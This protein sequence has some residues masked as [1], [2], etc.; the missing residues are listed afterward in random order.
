MTVAFQGFPGAYSDLASRTVFPTGKTIPCFSFEE[1]FEKVRKGIVDVG[2]IPIDNSIAGREADIHHLLPES[3][4]F[5]VGE[6][7]QPVRHQLLAPKGASLKKVKEVHSH[8]HALNQC[9][10]FIAAHKLKAV[11]HADTAGAA[12]DIAARNDKGVAAVASSLAGEIYHLK[13]LSKDIE[14][15][16]H[17]TTRFII[18]AKKPNADVSQ[19]RTPMIT[20]FIFRVRSVPAALYKA[21]GGFATNDVNITKLES[22][23]IDPQFTVAQFYVDVEGHPEEHSMKLAFEELAFFSEEVRVLGVYPAHPFRFRNRTSS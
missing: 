8:I 19:P 5:I 1:V 2:I 7:F 12:A 18:V 6:H 11:V 13:V 22:Y 14:D 3:K 17:N 16:A 9:R 10:K 15:Q 21:I 4:V 23:I 20:S